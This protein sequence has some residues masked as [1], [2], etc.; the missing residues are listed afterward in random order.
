MET[1][2][3]RRVAAILGA[4][5]ADA[6]VQPLHWN[7]DTAKLDKLIGPT[8][9]IA[10]WEPSVNPFYC[11]QT[12]K[13]SGYGDQAL[14]ILRSLVKNKGL[15]I[16]SLKN[17]TYTFF[18]PESEYENPVNAAYKD[19][20][21]VKKS[22]FPI[23]GP[24]RHFS[25]KKFIANY[26]EGMVQTGCPDDDQI[27]GVLRIIPVVAMYAG[28]SDM[29]NHAEDVVR[30]TQESDFTVV[31]ALCAARI[32]EHF[33]LNGASDSVVEAVIG[34]LEDPHRNNPQELDRA[35]IGKLRQVR[36]GRGTDHRAMSKQFRID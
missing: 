34:Q 36:Q 20:S 17:D 1:V 29:L 21:D 6:A 9:D 31:V 16:P 3:E 14:V 33:I 12:G 25:V 30:I 26:K 32:L 8:D 10:F 15:D 2:D 13:Q 5:V 22:V 35:M 23:K 7:Y 18:G 28:Q 4:V 27:D 24:W 19:K 11:I